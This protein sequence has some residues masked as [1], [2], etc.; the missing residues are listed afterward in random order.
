MRA[1]LPPWSPSRRPLPARLRR[2]AGVL[3]I[4]ATLTFSLR[5]YLLL[6]A[7]PGAGA[8]PLRGLALRRPDCRLGH[9]DHTLGGR[10][11][12]RREAPLGGPIVAIAFGA[13]VI[14]SSAWP[15]CVDRRENMMAW[16]LGAA[17]NRRRPSPFDSYAAGLRRQWASYRSRLPAYCSAVRS[18]ADARA[19]LDSRLQA[20]GGLETRA[21][22]FR[23]EVR[24]RESLVRSTKA[25]RAAAERAIVAGYRLA[26]EHNRGRLRGAARARAD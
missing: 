9:V 6:S 24:I 17:R 18:L 26:I 22:Q 23:N 16:G 20:V 7:F 19:R 8:G 1:P 13:A 21:R 15:P 11:R 12:G 14:C 3:G 2:R 5:R 25:V 10:P 4:S